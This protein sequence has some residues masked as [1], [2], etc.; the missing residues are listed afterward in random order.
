MKTLRIKWFT[1]RRV[2]IVAS[3]QISEASANR[4]RSTIIVPGGGTQGEDGWASFRDILAQIILSLQVMV[5]LDVIYW[6]SVISD[7]NNLLSNARALRTLIAFSDSQM[8]SVRDSSLSLLPDRTLMWTHHPPMTRLVSTVV[9]LP[10]AT[11]AS[12]KWSGPTRRGSFLILEATTVVISW[13][14]Q[15]STPDPPLLLWLI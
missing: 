12:Q 11:M 9:L 6:L 3:I 1:P 8:M 15:R 7:F 4:N 5:H 14:Y 10:A 13:R 2:I